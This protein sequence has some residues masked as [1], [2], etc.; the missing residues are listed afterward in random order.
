MKE[1]KQ[2]INGSRPNQAFPMHVSWGDI[3]YTVCWEKIWR[4]IWN[5]EKN[6]S[7]WEK[8]HEPI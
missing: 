8:I 6:P 7:F 3:R 2:I 5:S 4:K 1:K